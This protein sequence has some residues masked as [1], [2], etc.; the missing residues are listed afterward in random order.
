MHCML[1]TV[2]L[3]FGTAHQF[4]HC[5]LLDL[6]NG[7]TKQSNIGKVLPTYTLTTQ[8]SEYSLGDILVT[9]R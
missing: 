3:C 5:E 8:K 7:A 4:H 1:V 9:D 2:Y 6:G